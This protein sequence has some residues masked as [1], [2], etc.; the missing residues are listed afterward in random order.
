VIRCRW[1]YGGGGDQPALDQGRQQS[2]SSAL[3]GIPRPRR[4]LRT[5]AQGAGGRVRARS[6]GCDLGATRPEPPEAGSALAELRDG[7]A[8]HRAA[9]PR[10]AGLAYEEF[11]A[12]CQLGRWDDALALLG[13]LR[14]LS[15][16][17]KAS[18]NRHEAFVQLARN[19]TSKAVTAIEPAL[20]DSVGPDDGSPMAGPVVLAVAERDEQLAA[21]L[22]RLRQGGELDESGMELLCRILIAQRR[23]EPALSLAFDQFW[24]QQRV[25]SASDR[26]SRQLAALTHAAAADRANLTA[27]RPVDTALLQLV[28]QGP[29]AGV[30]AFEPLAASADPGL[31]SMRG[32]L[33]AATLSGDEDMAAGANTRLLAWLTPRRL[34]AWYRQP[35]PGPQRLAKRT[36]DQMAQGGTAQMAEYEAFGTQLGRALSENPTES[37]VVTYEPLWQSHQLL[38]RSILAR[39]GQADELRTLLR[40]QGR[41]MQSYSNNEDEYSSYN[42]M[43]ASRTGR[44][45]PNYGR[46][47]DDAAL[48][49]DPDLGVRR[50]LWD[51]GRLDT[52]AAE[53]D[54]LALRTPAG[55]STRRSEAYAAGDKA[56]QAQQERRRSALV[57][58]AEMR[59]GDTPDL[60]TSSQD[61]RYRWYW[62]S[63]NTG[64]QDL[65]VIRTGLRTQIDDERPADPDL[66]P[67]RPGATGALSEAALTDPALEQELALCAK[68]IGPGWGST[69][70]L[71]EVVAYFRATRRPREVLDL[72]QRAM[73]TDQL[74][75]SQYLDDY[76][77]ACYRTGAADRLEA[78]LVSAA[79]YGAPSRTT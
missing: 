41:T 69:R 22:E 76:V 7:L 26:W 9:N 24:K 20:G 43:L 19:D 3:Y 16:Q 79:K 17:Q 50:S 53:Y 60:G 1:Y 14:T 68:D 28:T 42:A 31:E 64:S 36:M 10:I 62:Y 70:T 48:R 51:A 63:Y 49:T 35:T 75:R 52:L 15:P 11:H 5:D 39:A 29:A 73:E 21:H 72:L 67:T 2:I 71:R 59:A 30:K 13:D 6:R 27:Q 8:A 18:W 45:Y 40:Q 4:H 66:S 37:G 25:L 54:T 44:Y 34:S 47:N 77:W 33:L 58:L 56:A 65:Q 57:Q 61:W 78:V 38:Q 55:E 74:L 23:W 32:L 12:D 46:N